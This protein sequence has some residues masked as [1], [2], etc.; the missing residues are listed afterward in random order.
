MTDQDH[1]AIRHMHQL[2]VARLALTGATAATIFYGLCWLAAQV[3]SFG[4][5]THMYLQLFTNA[6]LSST[7]ALV[8]GGLWSIAFGLLG[9]ALVAAAY[10]ALAFIDRR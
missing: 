5:V 6:E 7:A 9:G 1:L 4:P 10:N 8:Q 2:G 3:T